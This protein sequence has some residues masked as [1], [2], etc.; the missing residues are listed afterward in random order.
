MLK[1]LVLTLAGLAA[2]IGVLAGLKMAQ[3][4]AMGA[5][6]AHMVMPPSP[7]TSAPVR[8]DVWENTL[9]ATGSVV[10]VQGVTVAAELSGKVAKI[11]FESGAS[12]NAGDLL[13]QLDTSTEEA[14]LRAAEA[15]AAWAKV[16]LERSTDLLDKKA[17]SKSD[18]DLVDAQYKQAVAQA[19]NIRAVI[20]K[21]TIRAPFSGRLGIRQVN[22]GQILNVGD[23]I[24]T[25]QTLD[26]IYVNFSLPQQNMGSIHL[27]SVVRISTDAAPGESFEGK[28]TAFN[29][30]IDAVTRSVRIQATLANP[31]EKLHPG[32]FANVE[33]VLPTRENVL[34]IPATAVLYAPY[35]DSV[36][37]VDEKKNEQTGQMEKVLRQQFIRIGSTRGDFVTIVSGLKE[38]ENVVTSGVFKL[39]PGMPVMV[40]NRLAP[41]AQ[42]SPTPDNT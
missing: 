6:Q 24:T 40:D 10:T 36:F 42:L 22:L 27:G 26:P 28:V 21:K 38:G 18:Y 3:F 15:S 23:P 17:I 11:A 14:Q 2:V 7:V 39:R 35:G 19:D 9:T 34:V 16:N 30:D 13:V 32:M 37:V 25:L 1:K 41:N 4:S 8:A 29:P 31:A 20:E 5:Q 33:I 12:V